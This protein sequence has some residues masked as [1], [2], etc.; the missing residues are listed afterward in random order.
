MDLIDRSA[1][2]EM[3]LRVLVRGVVDRDTVLS[4]SGDVQLNERLIAELVAE[5]ALAVDDGLLYVSDTGDELL[6]RNLRVGPEDEDAVTAFSDEFTT[7]DLEVKAALTDW[8][9][10]LREDDPDGQMAA[11]ERWL[12]VDRRLHGAADGKEAVRRVLGRYLDRLQEA[13]GAVLDGATDQLSG[14]GDASYHSLWFLLH[15]VLIRSLGRA[16]REGA[17]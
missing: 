6:T 17:P 14:A 16:R 12:D 1:A 13:R 7:L 10:A 9:R 11:V 3:L 2:T 15:E 5:G 4:W 8:Q